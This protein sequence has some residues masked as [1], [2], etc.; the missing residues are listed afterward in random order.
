M[1]VAETAIAFIAAGWTGTSSARSTSIPFADIATVA[2]IGAGIPCLD[3]SAGVRTYLSGIWRL[4][5]E[6]RRGK[7]DLEAYWTEYLEPDR[8]KVTWPVS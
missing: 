1:H 3:Q 5:V 4:L 2:L 7:L 8:R 6:R